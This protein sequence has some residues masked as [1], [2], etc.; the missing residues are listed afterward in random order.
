MRRVPAAA[1]LPAALIVLVAMLVGGSAAALA[2][3]PLACIAPSLPADA[4][5]PLA[6][7]GSLEFY[8]DEGDPLKSFSRRFVLFGSASDAE[9]RTRN[10]YRVGPEEGQ[11]T[12]V[13]AGQ[14]AV[15]FA[16]GALHETFVSLAKND[17]ETAFMADAVPGIV[18][19]TVS[20]A[21]GDL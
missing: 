14:T 1:V 2:R 12:I 6:G 7:T 15:S 16:V 20:V 10:A 4:G 19:Y 11:G 17:E 13:F 8:V 18:C 9:G 5:K 3:G 21:S